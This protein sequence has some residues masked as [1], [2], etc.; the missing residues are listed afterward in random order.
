MNLEVKGSLRILTPGFGYILH[1]KTND[2]Y[3]EKVY[4]G[5]F[6]SEDEYEEVLNKDF[7]KK[8]YVVV[9]AILSQVNTLEQN[10][11]NLMNILDEELDE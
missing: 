6:A 1:H 3:S 10:S 9:E 5:K 11:I 2:T 4:L 8:L 7:D